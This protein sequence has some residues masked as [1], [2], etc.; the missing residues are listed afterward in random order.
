MGTMRARAARK[1]GAD[2]CAVFDTDAARS[3]AL[4]DAMAPCRAATTPSLADWSDFDAVFV[5][6]P[7]C[8]RGAAYEALARSIPTFIEKPI[9]LS[10]PKAAELARLASRQAVLTAVGYMN[11]YRASVRLARQR[12]Q[13][14]TLLGACAH[15]VNGVYKVP[16]WSCVEQSGGP[17][18]EQATH[19]V[20]LARFLL[21]EPTR[22]AASATP[23][24][25]H[26]HL[27][28]NAVLTLSF[29]NAVLAS[30]FY[31]CRADVKAI[32]FRVFTTCEEL[33]L[34]GWD[35]DLIDPEDHRLLA[36]APTDRYT[37][38]DTETATFLDAIVA[39][40]PSTILCN[41]TDAL[42]TQHV[43]DAATRALAEG[44]P[45]HLSTASTL[46]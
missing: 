21:G 31:S 46:F 9:G 32:S 41:L 8:E 36:P 43:L 45:Q 33:C 10:A 3:R 11:R 2:V 42:R 24:P 13:G 17:L 4:A 35:L 1:W 14:Q 30:L 26:P 39:H 29:D 22:V 20:D 34:E 15:W 5:C 38:F 18:N 44:S 40:K 19:F 12:L 25:T 28:G 7:P 27:V 23:H 37:I 16:W 6:T